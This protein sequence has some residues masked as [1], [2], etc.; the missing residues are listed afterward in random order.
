MP[1]GVKHDDYMELLEVLGRIGVI[2]PGYAEI[3]IKRGHSD[4]RLPWVHKDDQKLH[5]SNPALGT[6]E[7]VS[8]DNPEGRV[9]IEE[10]F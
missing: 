1:G 7:I 5:T 8:F 2:E 10:P 6:S 9:A 3:S 4:L